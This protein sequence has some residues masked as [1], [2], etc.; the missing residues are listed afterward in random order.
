MMPCRGYHAHVYFDPEQREQALHL[1]AKVQR[2]SGLRVGRLHEM[3]VGPHAKPMF[4]VIVPAHAMDGFLPWLE[5]H[6]DGLDIL[7][8]AD[9]GDD[10]A[11]HTWHTTWLGNALPL[12]LSVL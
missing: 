1:R 10:L 5:K 3:P 2:L 4:Q 12:D 9:T 6:R 11:D 8:H 7:I